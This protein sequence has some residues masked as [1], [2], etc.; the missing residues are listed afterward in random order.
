ME[1]LLEMLSMASRFVH[2]NAKAMNVSWTG[3]RLAG[4]YGSLEDWWLQGY[5]EGTRLIYVQG[6]IE[7]TRLIYEAMTALGVKSD[8]IWLTRQEII[9]LKEKWLSG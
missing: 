3:S 5:I 7:G 2:A 9:V 4:F 6:Y 1:S 8:Y